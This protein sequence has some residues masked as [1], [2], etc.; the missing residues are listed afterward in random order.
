MT[1]PTST[2]PP[3]GPEDHGSVVRLSMLVACAAVLQVAESLFPHPLPG[4][5]LG[6]ANIITVIA[7]VYIG[8][9]SAIQLAVLRTLISSMVLGTFLTPTFVLSFSGGVVSALVMVLLFRVSGRGQ[10]SFSLIG[11][12][13]GGAVGHIATQVALVYL[14]FIRSSGVLWLWP[15]LCLAAVVTGILTGMIAVQAV[16]SLEAGDGIPGVKDSRGLVPDTRVLDSSNLAPPSFL[17]RLQPEIKIAAVVVV[18]LVVVVFSGFRLYLAV[19]GLLAMLAAL[20]RIGPNRLAAGL[21]R[22]WALLVMSLLLPVVFS[23]WGRIFFSAGP[24]RVTDQ[25]LHAG[26]IFTARILLL[27]FATALLSQTTPPSEVASGLEKL[28]RPLRILHVEPGRLARSL[29]LSW[30]YFPQFQ[31]Y[32]R[33]L[34]RTSS[35]RKGWFYRTIHLPGDVIANMFRLAEQVAAFEN[36]Q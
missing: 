14:L 20:G 21:K 17:S 18:G 26:A 5:R 1:K 4:V 10:F 23:P 3:E 29:G 9:S 31:Q 25:G 33:G 7:L 30:S 34:L 13:V 19:F 24:L 11:I 36:S 2:I 6:L 35:S 8:P 12:S 15:W 22:V 27:F 28:L 16:R 32:V